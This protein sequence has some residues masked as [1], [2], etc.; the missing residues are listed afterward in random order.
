MENAE[1][2]L[3][4]QFESKYNNDDVDN[5]AAKM[6]L[7]LSQDK[8]G[9]YS[10]VDIASCN[11]WIKLNPTNFESI[12]EEQAKEM[13]AEFDQEFH[14]NQLDVCF[15][16]M[17]GMIGSSANAYESD[18]AKRRV[19]EK[20]LTENVSRS[21]TASI[22]S[23]SSVGSTG[24]S[25]VAPRTQVSTG[26]RLVSADKLSEFVEHANHWRAYHMDEYNAYAKS[27][28][29]SMASDFETLVYSN[30]A[31]GNATVQPYVEAARIIENNAVSKF[32]MIQEVML[33]YQPTSILLLNATCYGVS[34]QGN[35]LKRLTSI[36]NHVIC[37]RIGL[38]RKG[39]EIV[40]KEFDILAEKQWLGLQETT[41]NFQLG[42]VLMSSNSV[43]NNIS[44]FSNIS[45]SMS[46]GSN[47]L[48]SSAQQ[49]G[50]SIFR[51]KLET[52]YAWLYGYMC[53]CHSDLTE[54]LHIL[55]ESSSNP[56]NKNGRLDVLVSRMRPSEIST[57]LKALENEFFTKKNTLEDNLKEI[58]D[59]LIMWNSYFGYNNY[60]SKAVDNQQNNDNNEND[61]L[62]EEFEDE[63][64]E[65]DNASQEEEEESETDN[66]RDGILEKVMNEYANDL[67]IDEDEPTD[68]DIADN[69]QSDDVVELG[70]NKDEVDNDE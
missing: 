21:R 62:S 45:S 29:E 2:I 57:N 19:R 60:F 35:Y 16:I 47:S 26:G 12:R 23:M 39:K 41:K 61:N 66:E 42:S 69:Y 34:N 22:A 64:Q 25:H 18:D 68:E 30:E 10:P 11:C 50:Y 36:F 49:D 31:D 6:A 13:A 37:K 52:K 65:E 40:R 14:P 54:E 28:I 20:E 48:G 56:L 27:I 67:D 5:G 1:Q 63:E 59:K 3:A 44:M 15:K 51:K 53:K 55:D 58:M 70:E 43:V 17:N 7:F 9:K 8:S 46:A 38:L 4:S 33:T 24:A 32:I